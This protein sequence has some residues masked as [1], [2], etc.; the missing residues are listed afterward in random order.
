MS[1]CKSEA[2]AALS[3]AKGAHRSATMPARSKTV[4]RKVDVSLGGGAP[5]APITGRETC[6]VIFMLINMALCV[7]AG[8]LL[9]FLQH[10]S[11]HHVTDSRGT[12][13]SA[14]LCSAFVPRSQC[15][16]ILDA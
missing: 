13:E 5:A 6:L 9:G 14:R 3:A 16:L 11:G 15:G 2:G 1:A 10:K 7:C 8:V 12:C 4:Y